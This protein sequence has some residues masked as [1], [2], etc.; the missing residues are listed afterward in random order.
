VA[1]QVQLSPKELYQLDRCPDGDA[2]ETPNYPSFRPGLAPG[3]GEECR[4]PLNQGLRN[5][6]NEGNEDAKLT[7]KPLLRPCHRF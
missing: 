7:D 1:R 5:K 4:A 2:R 6:S 3:Q